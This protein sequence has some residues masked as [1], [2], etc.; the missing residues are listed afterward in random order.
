MRTALPAPAIDVLHRPGEHVVLHLI[1]RPEPPDLGRLRE[2]PVD[3][4]R[5][6]ETVAEGRY[7]IE[8]VLT[9]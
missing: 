8:L 1:D 7:S 9:S 6:I 3:A 5:V 2:P 4:A